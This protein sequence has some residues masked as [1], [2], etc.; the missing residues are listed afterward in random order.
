MTRLPTPPARAEIEA[1][2]LD[3]FDRVQAR[4]PT[5]AA[6]GYFDALLNAPVVCD[7]LNTTSLVFHAADSRGTFDGRWRE[8]VDVV[9]ATELQSRWMLKAHLPAA[10]EHGIS[11]HAIQAVWDGSLAGLDDDDAQ[12]VD[13]LQRVVRGTV[14]DHSFQW[15]EGRLGRRAAVEYTAFICWVTMNTRLLQA[16]GVEEVSVEEIDRALQQVTTREEVTR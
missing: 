13:Y 5:G 4:F 14:D 9:V 6:G 1:D 11:P 3:A 12:L 8:W 2:E 10:I 7:A 15:L 16:L